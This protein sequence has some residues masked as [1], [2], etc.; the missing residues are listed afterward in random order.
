MS[1][2]SD[3][4]S[5]ITAA[6]DRIRAGVGAMAAAPIR[7]APRDDDPQVAGLLAQLAE[8]KTV[9]AQLE[10]RVS[11][12][13]QRQDGQLADLKLRDEQ[14]RTR[15]ASVDR[16]IQ[17]LRQANA[18]LRAS[19]AKLRE[20]L[21]EGVAEPHL[22]NKAMLAELDALRAVRAADAAEVDLVIDA[23]TPIIEEAR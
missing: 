19:N 15:L 18:D 17:K 5:R 23:L 13:K 20:A 6:L 7:D 8:E 14:G 12:L 4:E 11:A 22:I 10:E 2:I 21:T 3:L 1:E 16:D 9:T